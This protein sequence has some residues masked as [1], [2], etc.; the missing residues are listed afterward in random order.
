MKTT[1]WQMSMGVSSAP[2]DGFDTLLQ[3]EINIKYKKKKKKIKIYV[4]NSLCDKTIGNLLEYVLHNKLI[5]RLYRI[6]STFAHT[7][8]AFYSL[9]GIFAPSLG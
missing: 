9:C 4:N 2:A 3:Y 6:N 1:L 7:S 5:T 8:R